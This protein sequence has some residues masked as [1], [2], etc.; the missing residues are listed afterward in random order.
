MNGIVVRLSC[1]AA[2]LLGA[3]LLEG[4]EL[5]AQSVGEVRAA[6]VE[7]YVGRLAALA[8]WCETEELKREAE[9]TRGWLPPLRPL[10]LFVPIVKDVT[11]DAEPSEEAAKRSPEW[12]SR[13][14]MLRQTQ[15]EALFAL[16][17]KAVD[18]QQY[19]I[20]FELLHETLR[21]NP[22]HEAARRLLGYR[23]RDGRWLTVYEEAKAKANQVWDSRFGWL[24]KAQL[25]RYANGERFLK[26]RWISAE[27]DARLRGPRGWEVVTEH[28]RVQTNHS[29]E[30]GVRLAARLERLYDV[31]RQVFVRY[32]LTDLELGKLLT[33]VGLP[34]R[35]MPRHNVMYFRNRAQYNQALKFKQP[36]IAI[37]T[38]YYEGNTKI[39]YFFAGE[40]QD[41]SNLYHEA[42]HQLFSETRNVVQNIGRDA[43]FWVIEGIACYM[44]S[45]VEGDRYCTLGGA[46]T[47]RLENAYSRLVKDNFYVPL[48][49][50]TAIGMNALQRDTRI[51]PLYSES[52][53]LTYFLMYAD[54]GRYRDALVD[55]LVAIYTGRAGPDTLA[56]LTQTP[57]AQL[58]QQY[59]QFIGSL[60][61]E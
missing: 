50:L 10:V 26:G 28:Y 1:I 40:E 57:Y 48:A 20:G 37:T 18:E 11:D 41:D 38:G 60:T 19:S 8:Q 47:I 56:E 30:E 14:G 54:G 4:A 61:V 13:F 31:W 29:L 33:G 5:R 36:N 43:N 6:L 49:E 17:A 16:V 42:T 35:A 22:D 52:S 55:Y 53:G 44:E 27:E 7:N 23:Q 21:E 2:I 46:D 15:A 58:D 25:E 51:S 34:P 9:I 39:A 32:Y 24:P 12:Q 59:R 45:L 3:M